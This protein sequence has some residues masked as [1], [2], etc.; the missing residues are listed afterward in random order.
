MKRGISHG[1]YVQVYM[2]RVIYTVRLLAMEAS[3]TIHEN[4]Y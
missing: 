3:Y 4:D 2:T 1:I